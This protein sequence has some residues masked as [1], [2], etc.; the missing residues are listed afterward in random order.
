M[1]GKKQITL[2]VKI[3]VS[4][5]II[6]F[7]LYRL[8]TRELWATA[9]NVDIRYLVLGLLFSFVMVAVSCW[10]WWLILGYQGTAI[11]FRVLYRWY[12][13]GYFYSNFLP[14]NLGGDVARAWLVG[15]RCGSGSVALVSVF[16]ERFTGM[17][18]LLALAMILPFSAGDPWRHPAVWTIMALALGLFLVLILL[19]TLGPATARST[20]MGHLLAR[21]RHLLR[22]DQPERRTARIW[23]GIA[24]RLGTLMSKGTQLL[25]V[26]KARPAAFF[27]IM[28]L[29]LLFYVFTLVNVM[30]AY[31]AFGLWPNMASIAAIL[32][33]ALL[34][35]MLPISLGNLGVAEGAYVFYFGLTGLAGEL[36][37]AMGLFL[38]L[39]VL[40][41]GF[42]GLILHM[43][44]PS[45]PPKRPPGTANG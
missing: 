12:F 26:M 18:V 34:V 32:P 9:R 24:D 37:L 29:S 15:R 14:S 20:W 40:F 4:L 41:L 17:M 1:K 2:F 13:I 25:Q 45:V 19:L 39:K 33:V 42:I 27:W 21:L 31:R 7:L 11:P 3:V 38:R 23:N 22:A 10:K 44:E 16:A 43:R 6:A 8:D 35:A 28:A 5:L 36:T 30:L